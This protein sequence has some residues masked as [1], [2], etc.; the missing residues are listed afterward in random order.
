[1]G[2]LRRKKPR[3]FSNKFGVLFV[4]MATLL[5]LWGCNDAASPKNSS[6][7]INESDFDFGIIP[8]S[9]N[10]VQHSFC[11]VN[12]TD[13]TCK[14]TNIEKSCGCTKIDI[15]S[16][17]VLPHDST[18]FMVYL[19]IGSNYSFI[20]KDVNIYI[21][22]WDSPLTLYLRATRKVPQVLIKKEFP[23]KLS[24]NLRLSSQSALLGFAQHEQER[25]FSINLLNSSNE[26]KHLKLK[27]VLPDGFDV[28]CPSKIAP[29]EIS[30]IIFTCKLKDTLWGEISFDCIFEDDNGMTSPIKVYVIATEKFDKTKQTSPRI[31]VPITAY[32]SKILNNSNCIS[33]KF[34]NVG[35]DT[36]FIRHIQSSDNNIKAYSD[37]KGCLPKDTCNVLVEVLNNYKIKDDVIIGVTTNDKIEPYKQLRIIK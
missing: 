4:M 37:K 36:L 2:Q 22:G 31:C 23:F 34:I 30:R 18:R 3:S 19:D 9:I 29:Q 20:E 33:F 16:Y 35:Q 21:E 24:D 15:D 6:I 27:S 28:I 26:T 25:S 14:I 32:D 12:N 13:D 10:E 11:I 1:M 7:Y 5:Y 17:L 8:D